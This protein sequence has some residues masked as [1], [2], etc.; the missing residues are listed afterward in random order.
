MTLLPRHAN[1]LWNYCKKAQEVQWHTVVYPWLDTNCC[2]REP[3]I[4]P[5]AI[6]MLLPN[7]KN[8]LTAYLYTK[9]GPYLSASSLQAHRAAGQKT[10]CL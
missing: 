9:R 10:H 6:L 8:M 5:K 1:G 2:G 7:L 3:V 4:D